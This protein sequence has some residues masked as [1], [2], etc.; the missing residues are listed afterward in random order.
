MYWHNLN[1]LYYARKSR[2]TTSERSFCIGKCGR[3]IARYKEY[4]ANLNAVLEVPDANLKS[5]MR[6]AKA[7]R[8][9]QNLEEDDREALKELIGQ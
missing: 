7:Y 9:I 2:I 5:E 3:Y 1:F 6:K 8:Y 4:I